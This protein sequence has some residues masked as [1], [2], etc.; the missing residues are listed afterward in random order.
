MRFT[1]QNA[2]YYGRKGGLSATHKK[3]EKTLKREAKRISTEREKQEAAYARFEAAESG[4]FN[5]YEM[6]DI[7][8]EKMRGRQPLR[9][10]EADDTANADGVHVGA[11][12]V[13]VYFFAPSDRVK[14]QVRF[15]YSIYLF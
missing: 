14:K 2:R 11:D 8:H 5:G 13:T 9:V 4:S 1:K 7:F 10:V 12:G 15:N 3:S 6:I